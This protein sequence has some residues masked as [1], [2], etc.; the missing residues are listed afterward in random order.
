MNYKDSEKDD[1]RWSDSS[2]EGKPPINE[3]ELNDIGSSLIEAKETFS[4]ASAVITET[5]EQARDTN[6]EI[7]H[8]GTSSSSTANIETLKAT[9]SLEGLRLLMDSCFLLSSF[10]LRAL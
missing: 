4:T 7:P 8:K 5:Y 1:Q 9:H 10:Y 6:K 3:L 2:E